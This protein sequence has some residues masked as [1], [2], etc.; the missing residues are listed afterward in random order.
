VEHQVRGVLDADQQGT[1]LA[2][3][4]KRWQTVDNIGS[5]GN[6]PY[7][8]PSYSLTSEWRRPRARARSVSQPSDTRYRRSER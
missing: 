8:I 3:T 2:L 6:P 7:S 4:Q 5:T 1:L